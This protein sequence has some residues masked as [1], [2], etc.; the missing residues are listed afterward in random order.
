M[1]AKCRAYRAVDS[2]TQARDRLITGRLNRFAVRIEILRC[3]R[4]LRRPGEESVIVTLLDNR[5]I[6]VSLWKRLRTALARMAKEQR[7]LQRL[8]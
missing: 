5:T 4:T 7:A 1:L 8:P 2:A 6:N 3:A